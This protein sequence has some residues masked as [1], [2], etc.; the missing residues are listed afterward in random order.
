MVF[1]TDRLYIQLNKEKHLVVLNTM[2][3][4]VSYSTKIT[5]NFR[6]LPIAQT[7]YAHVI[8]N[9]NSKAYLS[10]ET[11]TYTDGWIERQGES[12][13]MGV[14]WI[15]H[16]PT[17]FLRLG[18]NNKLILIIVLSWLK[19]SY[20]QFWYLIIIIW[21]KLECHEIHS[22]HSIFHTTCDVP[23]YEP[24]YEILFPLD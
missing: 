17:N 20:H 22:K 5:R 13:F 11:M 9:W 2:N 21:F 14:Y 3:M 15:E 6:L 19:R 24:I 18:Y 1:V 16:A 12:N 10:P 4:K 7:I 8:W 23:I